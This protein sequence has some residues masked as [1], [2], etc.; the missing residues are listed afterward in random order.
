MWI[1]SGVTGNPR[2]DASGVTGSLESTFMVAGSLLVC[3]YHWN[4]MDRKHRTITYKNRH[5]IVNGGAQLC[6]TSNG[7]AGMAG[8]AKW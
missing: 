4:Y 5:D 6:Y 3:V 7:D 1:L 2:R 8:Y